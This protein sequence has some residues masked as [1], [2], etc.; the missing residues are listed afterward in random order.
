L[1]PPEASTCTETQQPQRDVRAA[2]CSNNEDPSASV[3]A[4]VTALSIQEEDGCAKPRCSFKGLKRGQSQ[5]EGM[6][7]TAP[8]PCRLRT[9][10]AEMWE[11]VNQNI[12]AKF[13]CNSN[14]SSSTSTTT[15]E[16]QSTSTK[17]GSAT[18][19][20]SSCCGHCGPDCRCCSAK[21]SAKAAAT[22][23]EPKGQTQTQAGEAAQAS[24]VSAGP[25]V[26]GIQCA[27]V[28]LSNDNQQQQQQR[29]AILMPLE[30]EPCDTMEGCKSSCAAPGQP[31]VTSEIA[32]IPG[33]NQCDEIVEVKKEGDEEEEDVLTQEVSPHT[34]PAVAV[35][36]PEVVRPCGGGCSEARRERQEESG[37]SLAL[38]R[39]RA[40]CTCPICHDGFVQASTLHC[41]HSFCKMCIDRWLCECHSC[42]VCRVQV[43]KAPVRALC[44]DNT[45]EIA[46][47]NESC[48]TNAST[49]TDAQKRGIG[50]L[51]R[52]RE[53]SDL[54]AKDQAS[55]AELEGYL[56]IA[57]EQGRHFLDVHKVW[58]TR[59]Q[60]RFRT[61]IKQHKGLARVAYC[62]SVGLTPEFLS[63]ASLNCLTL[64]ARNMCLV[65]EC[66]PA[67]SKAAVDREGKALMN[68]SMMRDRLKLFM[69]YS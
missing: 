21:G 17:S 64:A 15:S 27:E 56:T 57:R 41:G 53:L 18:A 44:L 38:T 23:S 52:K 5:C 48:A 14:A 66:I 40:E 29:S 6:M 62:E 24:S 61:G 22:M 8:P 47:G 7:T 65:E 13:S 16:S 45:A 34:T 49:A 58:N 12:K 2:Q 20:S 46:F 36:S 55:K 9:S 54:H 11:C 68:C 43:V 59:E 31:H 51:Q 50:W 4:G 28:T 33:D 32:C 37:A 63:C 35:A 3:S 67:G 10:L 1:P 42:P 39:L 69:H 30:M 25:D 26:A 19:A 60:H